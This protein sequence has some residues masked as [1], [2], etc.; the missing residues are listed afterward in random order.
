VGDPAGEVGKPARDTLVAGGAAVDPPAHPPGDGGVD[1]GCER[2]ARAEAVRDV[3]GEVASVAGVEEV[4]H[5]LGRGFGRFSDAAGG[6]RP[7][8]GRI[9]IRAGLDAGD[10]SEKAHS[11]LR[12]GRIVAVIVVSN[13]RLLA[14]THA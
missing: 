13:S 11:V 1:R 3:V 6:D 12:V 4:A 10:G 14:T 5:P 2:R 9:G 8:L 7:S